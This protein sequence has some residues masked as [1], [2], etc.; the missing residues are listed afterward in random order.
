MDT[1]NYQNLQTH[2]TPIVLPL[3][4]TIVPLHDWQITFTGILIDKEILK[5][6]VSD[7]FL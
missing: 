6:L 5:K 2:T 7:E 3:D 4:E 1:I